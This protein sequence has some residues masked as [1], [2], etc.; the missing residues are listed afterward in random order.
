MPTEK[1]VK[2]KVKKEAKKKNPEVTQQQLNAVWDIIE[3]IQRNLDTL[4]DRVKRI[5]NRMGL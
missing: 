4:N 3:E 1:P 2:E 5:L